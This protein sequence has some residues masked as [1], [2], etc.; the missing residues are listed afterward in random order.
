MIIDVLEK[1]KAELILNREGV[2]HLGICKIAF[3]LRMLK[4]ISQFQNDFIYDYLMVN[5]PTKRNKY[6]EFTQNEYWVDKGYWWK[7]IYT[8]PE[9]RQIRIDYLT[10]LIANVK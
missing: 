9:T 1:I 7:P 10:K 5:K 8:S 2:I 4:I 3:D 6:K